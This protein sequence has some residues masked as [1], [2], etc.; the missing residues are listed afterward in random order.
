[1]TF[2]AAAGLLLA[3]ARATGF[4]TAAVADLTV[5]GEAAWVAFDRGARLIPDGLVL[6]TGVLFERVADVGLLDVL[7]S[8]ATAN[9][10]SLLNKINSLCCSYGA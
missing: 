8:T 7:V 1:V 9:L 5:A 3:K 2:L 10:Q 4:F 6:A